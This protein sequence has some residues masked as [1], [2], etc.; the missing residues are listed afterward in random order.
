MI[1]ITKLLK[2]EVA[3]SA[4]SKPIVAWN[5]TNRCNLNCCHC[6]ISAS[7]RPYQ[8]ELSTEE[9]KGLIND[10][11]N[12][13]ISLLLFSGGEPLLRPD[14]F[15]L[16]ALAKERKIESAISSNGSLI[17]MDVAKKI[18]DSGFSYVGIS[19][20]GLNETHNRFRA[21]NGAFEKAL[22]GLRLLKKEGI[23]QGVRFTVTKLNVKEL[24]GIIELV[25]EEGIKRLC[26]YNLV[27]TGRGRDITGYDLDNSERAAYMEY[28][29]KEADRLKDRLEILTVCNPADGVR[30]LNYM[31]EEEKERTRE[32]LLMYSGCSAGKRLVCIDSKG[33]IY[34]CQFWRKSLG[35]IREEG[36]SKIWNEDQFLIKLRE[37]EV[38]LTGRCG[39]CE[40]KDICGGCRVRAE[41]TNKD[42]W[43]EDPSCYI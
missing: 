35:N 27:Y 13:G 17:T 24:S 29:L 6:Y 32:H 19:L 37:K 4:M 3:I 28:L 2:K 23:K 40:H 18:K 5:I 41:F 10:L 39:E 36:F 33:N 15:E 34:P 16:G 7:D 14:I 42:I 31:P 30:L 38:H 21:V 8:N 43:A 9:S 25:L 1:R 11:A 20:D 26:I 12:M 22:N